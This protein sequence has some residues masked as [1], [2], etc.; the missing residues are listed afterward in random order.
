LV[1]HQLIEAGCTAGAPTLGTSG[2]GA[3]SHGF[4]PGHAPRPESSR[5]QARN[6]QR[7]GEGESAKNCERE[8]G[9]GK[10]GEGGQL[11]GIGEGR[12]GGQSGRGGEREGVR[13]GEGSF[14][15]QSM[16]KEKNH[17]LK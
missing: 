3:G 6:R 7:R 10:K 11:E 9:E 8:V 12:R 17:H 4:V 14:L 5:G 15:L 16:Q 13:K 2:G 1:D